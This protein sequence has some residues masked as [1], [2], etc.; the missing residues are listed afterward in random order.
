MTELPFPGKSQNEFNQ[1]TGYALEILPGTSKP[2]IPVISPLEILLIKKIF[3]RV[4]G[5]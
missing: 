2:L 1:G 5:W 4:F 3:E